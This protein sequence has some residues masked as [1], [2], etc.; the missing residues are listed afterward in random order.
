MPSTAVAYA[1][2]RSSAESSTRGAAKYLA[3]LESRFGNLGLALAA[4]NWGQGNLAKWLATKGA[5]V[6][7]IPAETRAY[8]LAITGHPVE[9]FLGKN[10]PST[11]GGHIARLEAEMKKPGAH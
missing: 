9:S 11:F 10:P 6:S 7:S 5:K 3:Q 2:D 1:V 4:Y 8:V